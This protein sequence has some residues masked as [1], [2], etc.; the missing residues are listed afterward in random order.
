MCD[1]AML[2]YRLDIALPVIIT[3]NFELVCVP[4]VTATKEV[5]LCAGLKLKIRA[6]SLET[7]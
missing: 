3:A 1:F 7:N 5:P 6:Q 4:Q 2:F